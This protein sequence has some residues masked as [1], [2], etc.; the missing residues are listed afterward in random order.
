MAEKITYDTVVS[1]T[2]LASVLGLSSRRVQQLQ[3]NG[4]FVAASRGHY[5]L[6]ECVQRYI[7]NVSK[8]AIDEDEAKVEKAKRMTIP[9]E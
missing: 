8:R 9:D 2:E 7:A 4:D 6:C 3:Q 1:T 5:N